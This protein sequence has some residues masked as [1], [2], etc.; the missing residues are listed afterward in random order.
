MLSIDR[1]TEE[2]AVQINIQNAQPGM[3]V[4]AEHLDEYR[5]VVGYPITTGQGVFVVLLGAQIGPLPLDA[6][7]DVDD[8]SAVYADDETSEFDDANELFAFPEF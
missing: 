6:M 2:D 1:S 5:R 4:T 8:S 3:Y 7:I